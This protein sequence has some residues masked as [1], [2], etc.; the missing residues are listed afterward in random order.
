MRNRTS[1]PGEE[2]EEEEEEER[3][4]ARERERRA[5]PKI[6]IINNNNLATAAKA[7]YRP[8]RIDFLYGTT[9]R[10]T[11]GRT[12]VDIIGELLGFNHF[13]PPFAAARG[14]EI[15]VGVIYASGAAGIHDEAGHITPYAFS[16]LC[17]NNLSC[18]ANINNAVLSF[19]SR[20]L[21]LVHKLNKKLNEAR[22]ILL[23]IPGMSSGDPSML[24]KSSTMQ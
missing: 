1:A 23:N 4:R 22:F 17:R 24:G 9:A 5:P 15:L 20:L 18:V 14:R 11:N 16:T 6:I 8:Y 21:S 7:N 13:I 3:E 12:T 10:F 19:N 2:E